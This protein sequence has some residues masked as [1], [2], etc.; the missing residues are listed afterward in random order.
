M[1]L[2]HWLRDDTAPLDAT[3]RDGSL[4]AAVRGALGHPHPVGEDGTRVRDRTLP[5]RI[6]IRDRN[7]QVLANVELAA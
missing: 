2:L 7:N 3:L 4:A 1:L 5:R 6:E